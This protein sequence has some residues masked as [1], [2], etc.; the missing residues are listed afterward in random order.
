L[1]AEAEGVYTSEKYARSQQ[2]LKRK[3]KFGII[4]ATFSFSLLLGMLFFNGFAITDQFVQNMTDNPIL[5]SLLF[6]AILGFLFDIISIPFEIYSTFRIEEEFGFNKTTVKTFIFDKLKSWIL[7]M[8]IGGGLLS[9]IIWIYIATGQWFALI[10]LIVVGFFGLFMNMFYTQLIVPIFNKLKPLPEGELKDA[11]EEFSKKA[12]FP[13]TKISVI[14]SSKRSTK[15]NAYFS[16]LG[17]KKRIVLFDT[18]IEK[19][20]VSELVA[21]LAHEIGHYKKKH[22]LK[23]LFTGLIQTSA[24]LYLLYLFLGYSIF[25]EAIG[26]TESSFHMGIVVFGLLYSPISLILGLF[27]NYIS[28]KNEFEADAFAARFGLAGALSDALK[29][30]SADNLSNLTPH[31]VYV[32]FYY[33]HPPLINR[34]QSISNIQMKI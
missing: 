28:R 15:S 6:F 9:L 29:K 27:D 19:H 34:L 21:V 2:Y 25:Q 31:P 7:T 4:T 5:Q 12:N 22:I 30:L 17:K 11:I 3:A 33:S 13:L 10:A 26:A 32:F 18:L 23:G 16:G 1:P 8:V 20:T 24:L 14:D